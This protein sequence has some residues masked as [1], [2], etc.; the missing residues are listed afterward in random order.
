M[1]FFCSWSNTDSVREITY[2]GFHVTDWL[3]TRQGISDGMRELNPV[4]GEH[5]SM[6]KINTI[7]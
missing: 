7:I 4:L 1:C 3:Q 2:I 5:P 6:G